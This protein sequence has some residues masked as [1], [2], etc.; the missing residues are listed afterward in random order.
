MDVVDCCQHS[1]GP[2]EVAIVAWAFLPETERLDARTLMDCQLIEQRAIG[3][4]EKSLDS[5]RK[6]SLETAQKLVDRRDIRPGI[7]KQVHVLGH[8]HK[9]R[10][11]VTVTLGRP[12]DLLAEQ[13][14]PRIVREQWETTE[15]RKRQFVAVTRVV[16][17]TNPFSMRKP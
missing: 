8:V 11:I 9:R 13:V 17:V 16:I 3:L 6:R 12:V 1:F 7:D 2:I 10:Q 14:S 4:L 5:N 15:T